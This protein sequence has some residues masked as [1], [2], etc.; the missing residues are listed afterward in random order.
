MFHQKL[1]S[2]K[3]KMNPFQK[4]IEWSKQYHHALPWRTDRSLYTTLV[5]EIMLQQTTVPTVLKHYERF[6][7]TYPN[8][9]KLAASSEEKLT[10][11]WKGLGYYRRA[12]NLLS[13][14][15]II[16][17]KFE[18][19][20]PLNYAD[21]VSI[22][23]IGDYTASAIIAIGADQPALAIDA[24]ISR[25]LSRYLDLSDKNINLRLKQEFETNKIFKKIKSFR[26]F[27]EAIMDLGRVICKA[28]SAD[29]AI[30]PLHETCLTV[31][32]NKTVLLFKQEKKIQKYFELE[33][34]RLVT[35]DKDKVLL[36][37]RPKGTWLEGQLDLPTFII[38]SEDEKLNQYP[39]IEKRKFPKTK[40]QLKS[41]ITKYNILNNIVEVDSKVVMKDFKSAKYYSLD[42][43]DK[44]NI[45]SVTLKI[46]KSRE[47]R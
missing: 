11:A 33:L 17:E 10:I 23:G 38:S 28:R 39:K 6:L 9:K 20:I 37:E 47:K 19:E 40:V 14:A 36:I 1:K 24:N 25:V 12:R 45:T 7:K 44:L 21:L 18:G 41:G 22:K 43:I 16:Q 46:L 26:A 3:I 35:V 27:N 13:A 8:L 2:L 42:Q 15:K 32:N 31:K 30:C 29:C 34:V 5:S 4:L